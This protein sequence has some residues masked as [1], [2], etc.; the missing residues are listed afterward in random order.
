MIAAQVR[1]VYPLVLELVKKEGFDFIYLTRVLDGANGKAYYDF[2]H[3]DSFGNEVVA[4]RLVE[5][6]L[7]KRPKKAGLRAETI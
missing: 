6:L 4:Q 3:L 7:S 1:A 2:C 5:N